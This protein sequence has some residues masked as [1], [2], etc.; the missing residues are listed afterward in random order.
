MLRVIIGP[1]AAGKSRLAMRLAGERPAGIISA[2]SRQVYRGFDIGTG[3]PTAEEQ[4]AVPHRG[5]DVLDP[6]QRYSAHAWAHDALRWSAELEQEGHQALIVG[7]T[8]FYVRAL[9]APLDPVP[10]LDPLRRPALEAWLERLDASELH[11]WCLQL[12]AAR[13]HLGRV[14]QLRAVETA[15]LSGR[16]LS[17]ALTGEAAP[18][19]AGTSSGLRPVRYLVVDPG[20]VLA[21]RIA[22][23]VHGMIEAGWFEEVRRLMASVPADAPA[24][25]ASG[26]E[27][28]R[29]CASGEIAERDAVERVVIET[30]QYAKRQRT[31]YRHQLHGG[32]VTTIDPDRPDALERALEWWDGHRGS[33]T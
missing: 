6:Q 27:M 18:S 13:A 15:V 12:D 17:D 19:D 14:Q 9:V 1:T 4:A 20:A 24:W 7:G 33:T 28:L 2:D 25:K 10:E 16:R 32:T 11:R 29:Q 22:Q 30:R 3:K 31:W 5:I 26:Y 23:R 21:D 8:G